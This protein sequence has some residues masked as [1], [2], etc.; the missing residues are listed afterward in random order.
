MDVPAEVKRLTSPDPVPS[1]WRYLRE[2]NPWTYYNVPAGLLLFVG[3]LV[4]YP[5]WWAS[6]G[7][8]MLLG[9][10]VGNGIGSWRIWRRRVAWAR[11]D[12]AW[13]ARLSSGE[14]PFPEDI[15]WAM[16]HFINEDKA[17]VAAHIA[18]DHI[19]A[20][21]PEAREW[22]DE[23]DALPEEEKERRRREAIAQADE[24]IRKEKR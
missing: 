3:M 10:A 24:D 15:A 23:F 20:T 6:L 19:K 9:A 22:F 18:I 2:K 16:V 21:D 1:F 5:T 12:A 14:K 11:E 17:H 8:G 13:V 7:S 4:F